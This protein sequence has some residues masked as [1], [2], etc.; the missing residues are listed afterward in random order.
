VEELMENGSIEFNTYNQPA[1]NVFAAF[2]DMT[3]SYTLPH[4]VIINTTGMQTR[5]YQ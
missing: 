5:Y 2:G 1:N 3:P 4:A